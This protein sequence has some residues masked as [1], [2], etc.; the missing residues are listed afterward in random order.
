MS[1]RA[2]QSEP[3]EDEAAQAAEAEALANDPD[4]Y[5]EIRGQQVDQWVHDVKTGEQR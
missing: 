2:R 5:D 3:S 1:R 4:P